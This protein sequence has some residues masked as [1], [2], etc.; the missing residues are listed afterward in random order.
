MRKNT[1][2][3][4]A[5]SA[6]MMLAMATPAF[7]RGVDISGE[8]HAETRGL[9][10]GRLTAELRHQYNDERKELQ[11]QFKEEKKALKDRMEQA[12]AELTAVMVSCIKPAVEKRET[13]IGAGFSAYTTAV[14]ATL[15]TRKTSLVAAWTLTD[16][17]ARQTAIRAAWKAYRDSMDTARKTLRTAR[18]SAW[19]QFATEVKAC[20][21][22]LSASGE[23]S[24]LIEIND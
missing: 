22:S 16:A 19:T 18:I 21:A 14:N 13:A 1:F 8:L 10:L 15:A 6:A 17:T 4:A 20:G 12:Q 7:A 3:K 9:S 5:V 11:K 24:H 2:I 23:S